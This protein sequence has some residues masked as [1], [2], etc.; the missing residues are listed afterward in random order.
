MRHD[1]GEESSEKALRV[2]RVRVRPA[3]RRERG[4]GDPGASAVGA[5]NENE[6]L[7]NMLGGYGI[8]E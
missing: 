7:D 3:R 2:H 4:A 8:H 1:R 6:V 5:H